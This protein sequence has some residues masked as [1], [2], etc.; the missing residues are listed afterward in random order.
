MDNNLSEFEIQSNEI[1]SV[2]KNLMEQLNECETIIQKNN[3]ILDN[4]SFTNE[5]VTK[6]GYVSYLMKLLQNKKD[7]L[8]TF[9]LE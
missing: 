2:N 9:I 8:I 1:M 3:E 7:Q 4:L 6:D 5:P